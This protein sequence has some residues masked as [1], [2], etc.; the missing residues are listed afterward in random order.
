MK[1]VLHLGNSHINALVAG[2]KTISQPSGHFFLPIDGADK[3]ISPMVT[4]SGINNELLTRINKI[5]PENDTGKLFTSFCFGGNYHNAIG[6]LVNEEPFD[7]VVPGFPEA[8]LPNHRVIPISQ[9]MSYFSTKYTAAFQAALAINKQFSVTKSFW[10]APPP[11]I[12]SEV[13]IRSKI[14][15]W[16]TDRYT[17]EF[18]VNHAHVRKK[19]WHVNNLVLKDLCD[20]NNIDLIATP[21]SMITEDGFLSEAGMGSDSTHG[22]Y[23][24][25]Q[26]VLETIDIKCE[27]EINA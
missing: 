22:S 4:N 12:K 9:L 27:M 2:N 11:P 23:R 18:L 8:I 21:K 3:T 19:L 25:G 24:F 7:L 26:A 6:L 1:R 15:K 5:L 17:T 13:T 20:K 14:E 10:I 16:F